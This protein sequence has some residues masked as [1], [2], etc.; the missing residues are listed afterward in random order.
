MNKRFVSGM[1]AA[2][3]ESD[4][5]A[6]RLALAFAEMCWAIMLLWPG[7]TFGRPTYTVMAQIAPE[8]CWAVAFFA[9]SILQ[10][11]IVALD[12]CKTRAAWVFSGWNTALWLTS[13]VA[14]IVSVQPPPAAIGGEMALALSALWI[15]ARPLLV[16][17][18]EVHCAKQQ[19]LA[20]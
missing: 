19:Q 11:T 9:T 1:S 10:F 8:L 2:L 7:D 5:V 15:F 16:K 3:F 14:M 12:L 17:R 13:I 18:G 6:T 4:L 20:L